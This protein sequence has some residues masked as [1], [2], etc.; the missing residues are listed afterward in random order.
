M[1]NINEELLGYRPSSKFQIL[2]YSLESLEQSY[3]QVGLQKV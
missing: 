1:L 2:Y 3:R